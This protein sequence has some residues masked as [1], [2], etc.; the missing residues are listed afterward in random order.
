MPVVVEEAGAAEV[1]KDMKIPLF[2]PPD[3]HAEVLA[4]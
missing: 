4:S 1:E 2:D 3:E